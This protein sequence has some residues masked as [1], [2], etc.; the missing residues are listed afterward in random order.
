MVCYQIEKDIEELEKL[1]SEAQRSRVKDLLKLEIR[2]LQTELGKRE[3]QK[4]SESAEQAAVKTASTSRTQVYKELLKTYGESHSHAHSHTVTQSCSQSHSHTVTLT[5][6]DIGMFCF[7]LV[8]C[9]FFM[10]NV[11]FSLFTILSYM[12]HIEKFVK[13][14]SMPHSRWTVFLYP[15]PHLPLV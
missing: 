8:S 6:I 4:E 13:L 7:C 3:K 2:R 9:P 10:S 14:W 11:L 1:E 5:V 12:R 15:P